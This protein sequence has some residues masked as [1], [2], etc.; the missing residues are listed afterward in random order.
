MYE[1]TIRGWKKESHKSVPG[2]TEK[3]AA[4]DNFPML[5]AESVQRLQILHMQFQTLWKEF[6]VPQ[7]V[8][9]AKLNLLW[10]MS[11]IL[12]VFCLDYL[13]PDL[14]TSMKNIC[15]NFWHPSQIYFWP[16]WV[17]WCLSPTTTPLTKT[18]QRMSKNSAKYFLAISWS[19]I[20]L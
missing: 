1:S 9:H 12:A 7:Y 18:P 5:F 2:M 11:T 3:T 17:M 6:I 4:S 10:F 15:Q 16:E 13:S 19:H 8:V 20:H 14:H